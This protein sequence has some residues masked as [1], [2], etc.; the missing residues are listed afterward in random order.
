LRRRKVERREEAEAEKGERVIDVVHSPV[1]EQFNIAAACASPAAR[2]TLAKQFPRPDFFLVQEHRP[3]WEAIL[4]LERRKLDFDMATVRQ[5]GG[6]RI[7][8]K[9]LEKL[10]E[11]RPDVPSEENLKHH[12]AAMVWDRQRALVVQGPLGQLVEAIRNPAEARSRVA[13]L[14]RQAA[15]AL[16]MGGSAAYLRDGREL[17][18]EMMRDV[19]ARLDGQ[20]CWP[21]GIEGL[22]RYE[23]G[24]RNDKGEDISG[25]FRLLP[26]A[27][28]GQ[29]TVVTA[30]SG[31]GK[32]ALSIHMMLGLRRQ[33]R[34]V[35]YGAWEPGSKMG[36]ELLACVDLGWNKTD[37]TEGRLSAEELV[38]LEERAHE[39]SR[40]VVFM[41]NPFGRHMAEKPSNA[42]NLDLIQEHVEQSGCDVFF[43]DLWDRCLEDDQSGPFTRALFRQQ[44]MAEQTK[45]HVVLLA[46]Q[47]IKGDAAQRS[48][49]RPTREGIKGTSA[50]VEIADQILAPH[51]PALFK[52]VTDNRLE[53]IVWKQRYG[54]WPQAVE[55]DWD[56]EYGSI[57]RGRSIPFEHIG[58]AGGDFEA[59]AAPVKKKKR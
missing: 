14:A 36:L 28:P 7:N 3:I 56:G 32:S 57:T 52:K 35:L 17:V 29:V 13:A 1:N 21:F 45:V 10:L 39:I 12:V 46:Q 19:R 24:A 41:D 22:D 55:F 6:D 27:A 2:T 44:A 47:L 43:A 23:E 40:D 5:L 26:G 37:L 31:G 9:Y 51:R 25:R 50:W 59:M 30:T 48:D 33:K 18:G 42:R 16:S 11:L 20:A 58:E 8:D 15:E 34:K 4:E 54:K 49:K 53:L 38:E